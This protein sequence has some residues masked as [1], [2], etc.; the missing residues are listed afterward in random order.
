MPSDCASAARSAVAAARGVVGG[1]G[2]YDVGHAGPEDFRYLVHGFISHDS[3]EQYQGALSEL[4][5]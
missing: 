2:K 5:V 1:A 4:L 3:E